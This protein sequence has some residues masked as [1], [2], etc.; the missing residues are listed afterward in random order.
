K[1]DNRSFIII[2]E[3]TLNAKRRSIAIKIVRFIKG[4]ISPSLQPS[5]GRQAQ[6][7][8]MLKRS[9][10]GNGSRKSQ[11]EHWS[12]QAVSSWKNA[13]GVNIYEM[14]DNPFFFEFP[15]KSMAEQILK[16]NGVGK[17]AKTHLE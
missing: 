9:E 7:F 4:D 15:T 2:P 11:P 10:P 3:V 5:L 17:K 13:F 16:G 8:Y 14:A 1:F 12:A 6:K